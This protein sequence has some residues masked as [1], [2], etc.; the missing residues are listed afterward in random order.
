ME[1]KLLSFLV[2]GEFVER[3]EKNMQN[4]D[5]SSKPLIIKNAPG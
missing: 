2:T 5:L 3:N 4:Q 1:M